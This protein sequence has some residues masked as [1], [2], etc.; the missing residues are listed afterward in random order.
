MDV[1]RLVPRFCGMMSV[2]VSVS[3][4]VSVSA[5]VSKVCVCVWKS[6]ECVRMLCVCAAAHNTRHE[7][8]DVHMSSQRFRLSGSF[9]TIL[10]N[11]TTQT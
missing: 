6:L 8:S 4:P 11:F 1:N 2:S 3:V 5:S 10:H 7:S 9:C